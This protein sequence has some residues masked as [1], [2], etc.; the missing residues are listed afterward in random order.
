MN[1]VSGFQLVFQCD[2]P[3]IDTSGTLKGLELHR[4]F[5]PGTYT[6]VNP[7]SG[8]HLVFQCDKPMK[9]TSSTLKG[10]ELPRRF[11]RGRTRS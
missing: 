1:P 4:R 2:R 8:F 7:V 3:M 5:L 9:D 6:V 10:L 11:R